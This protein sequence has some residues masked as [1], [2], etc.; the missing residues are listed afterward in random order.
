LG[1]RPI[2]VV[3]IGPTVITEPRRRFVPSA[4]VDARSTRVPER[5]RL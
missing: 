2:F 4:V 5:S 3:P 1:S